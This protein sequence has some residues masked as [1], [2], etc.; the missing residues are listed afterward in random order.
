MAESLY[1]VLGVA[2]D[3]SAQ[4]IKKAYR[5]LVRQHHPDVNP[6]DPGAEERFKKISAAYETLGDE[7]KRK[8]YDE[9]GDDATR[10]G[11][12]PEKARAYQQ[13]QDRSQWRPGGG[14]A[15]S[16]DM[17][18][19]VFEQLFGGRRPT[20][21]RPGPDLHAELATDFRTAAL[22]GVRTLTFAD[23]RSLDVRIPPG[24]EDGGTIRLRG[25]GGPG[26]DGGPPGDLLLTLRVAPHP[27]FRR[28]GLDL[29]LDLPLTVPEAIR[30]TQVDVP[31]LDGTVRLT[32][33]P[34]AQNGRKLRLKGRG[35]HRKGRSPGHLYAHIV[36]RIPD[37]EVSDEVLDGLAAAYT[38]DVREEVAP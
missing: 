24:V 16:V 21:P 30:G 6:G 20:G 2:K 34:G 10:L 17:D 14:R 5:R 29:H 1:D 15:Q 19:D 37:G 25:K 3:A 35:V 27:V 23:G 13:W 22:G 18:F 11:F 31:V 28:E 7:E 32:V 26:R 9:F 36:V 12:D 33:P 38:S 4:D 8:L